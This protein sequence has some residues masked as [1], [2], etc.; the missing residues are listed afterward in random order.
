MVPEVVITQ[1]QMKQILQSSPLPTISRQEPEVHNNTVDISKRYIEQEESEFDAF[2]RNVVLQLKALPLKEALE[3]EELI[4]GIL[5]RQRVRV[6]DR[7]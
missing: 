3:A 6:L 1:E 5:R 4:L 2:G 7:R